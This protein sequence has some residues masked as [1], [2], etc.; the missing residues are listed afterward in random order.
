MSTIGRASCGGASL[1]ATSSCSDAGPTPACTS[2]SYAA[3]E[4]ARSGASVGARGAGVGAGV[5]GAAGTEARGASVAPLFLISGAKHSEVDE[6]S[7]LGYRSRYTDLWTLFAKL[8][9][10]RAGLVKLPA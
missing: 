10:D 4:P 9:E 2:R 3:H 1:T 6:F 7:L 5:G 8:E